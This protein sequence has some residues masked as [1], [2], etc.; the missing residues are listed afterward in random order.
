[1]LPPTQQPLPPPYSGIDKKVE[2][3][4][5]GSCNGV[6]CLYDNYDLNIVLWNPATKETKVVPKST[7]PRFPAVFQAS[8]NGIGFGFDARTNDY[9]II[10]LLS[11]TD[12][13]PKLSY[14][15]I[16]FIDQNEVYS[17]STNSWRKV[18]NPPCIIFD[19]FKGMKAYANGI[20]SWWGLCGW[21]SIL[22]FDMSN[23][24]FLATPLP[25]E[26]IIGS[27][28]E[29]WREFFVLNEKVA[30]AVGV[31][32]EDQ[33]EIGFDVWLLNEYGVKESWAKLF[34]L[35]PFTGIRKP[36]GFWKNEIALFL[37][38][39]DGRL[40]VYDSSTKQMSGLQ[41]DGEPLSLQVIPYVETLV[42]VK[43]GNGFENQDTLAWM[44]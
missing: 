4:V 25:N 30:L 34:T 38:S 28:S 26:R 1:V 10:K 42:S 43:G 27:K 33:P 7:L 23:E 18:D 41:I 16:D 37:E 36:L 2:V 32:N 35:G 21:E 9:K 22:S 19:G 29:N 17:L 3:F 40:V 14:F 44:P 12:P 24:A 31:L 5:V 11:L 13:D 6:V 8:T 39:S 15:E 20:A